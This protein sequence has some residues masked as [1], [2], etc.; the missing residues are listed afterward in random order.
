MSPPAWAAPE[1]IW[2]PPPPNCAVELWSAP[3]SCA[4]ARS[5][6]PPGTNCTIA[7]E[8]AMMPRIVGIIRRR[9]RRMKAGIPRQPV[10]AE[11]SGKRLSESNGLGLPFV[12]PPGAGRA[13]PEFRLALG[14]GESVP[15]GDPRSVAIPHRDPIMAGAQDTVEHTAGGVE[16][17]ARFG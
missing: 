13:D 9:E 17:T 14:P 16:L 3:C 5:T 2:P 7:K 6:G 10:C 12:P 11:R 15:I 1:P 8:T 4:I